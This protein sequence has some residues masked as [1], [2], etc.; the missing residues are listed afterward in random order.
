MGKYH[1]LVDKISCF[2]KQITY[3]HTNPEEMLAL[4]LDDGLFV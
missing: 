1:T 3:I 2:Y 4:S